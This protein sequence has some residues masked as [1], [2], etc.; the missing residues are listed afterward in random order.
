MFE[1]SAELYPIKSNYVFLNSGG[2][3]PLFALALKA[4]TQFS[5]AQAR[6]G[7][8]MFG[9]YPRVLHN[10]RA[11]AG[12]LLGSGPEDIAFTK[13]SAEGLNIIANG[14]PFEPGDEIISY[15]HEYPSNHFPW[16]LQASRGVKL[17]LLS[18]CSIDGT[19]ADARPLAWSMDEL[20][21]LVTSRTKIVALSHV[22]FCSGFTADLNELGAFCKSKNIFLVID[23]AQSLGA[24]P[25]QP[26]ENYIS[27]VVSSGWKWL[28]GPIG[29]AIMYTNPEFRDML[30]LTLGGP[31]M[32]SQGLDYLNLSWSPVSSAQRFEYSTVPF[33]LACGLEAAIKGNALRYGSDKISA[34]IQ[35]LRSRL[36]A[37]LDKNK[38]AP[39]EFSEKHRSGILAIKT[40]C[41]P[42]AAARR[43]L[44]RGV[45]CTARGNYLRLAPHFYLEDTEIDR[46]AELINAQL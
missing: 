24:M 25:V 19:S 28:M 32:M 2:V 11:A 5:E 46:A 40:I 23:A 39:L 13:S 10:L 26:R 27:A 37:A 44:E 21:S 14:F 36:S 31:D 9:E 41:D 6:K 8:A 43:L 33:G 17:K 29:S 3:G 4:E 1:K 12:A 18:N 34:E 45:V 30:R 7:S 42:E 16:A 20:K 22:Q 35:R 15:I 38:C